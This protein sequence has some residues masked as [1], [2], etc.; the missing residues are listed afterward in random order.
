MLWNDHRAALSAIDSEAQKHPRN[1]DVHL[2]YANIARNEGD[3]IRAYGESSE[4]VELA[5]EWPMRMR[6]VQRF[7][8]TR[9]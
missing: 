4:G 3:W 6:C 2:T 5:P 8:I 7:V 1:A 9:I